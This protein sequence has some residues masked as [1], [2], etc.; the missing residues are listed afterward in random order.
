MSGLVVLNIRIILTLA[1]YGFVGWSIWVLWNDLKVSSKSTVM[2]SVPTVYLDNGVQQFKFSSPEV[3]IGRDQANE[4][5]IQDKAVSARHTRLSYHHGQW[6]V[7]DLKSRNGTF[8]NEKQVV[9]PIVITAG[10]MIRCATQ[11]FEVSFDE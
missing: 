5:P 4:L 6:W 3:I 10:D 9:N 8:L 11:E 1:I 2:K 7:E